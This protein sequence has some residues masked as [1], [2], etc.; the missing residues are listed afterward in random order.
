MANAKMVAG[1]AV[2]VSLLLTSCGP[3]PPEGYERSFFVRA[4]YTLDFDDPSIPLS[5]FTDS[6]ELFVGD[7]GDAD[8][9]AT[10]GPCRIVMEQRGL[11]PSGAIQ[12]SPIP[13]PVECSYESADGSVYDLEFTMADINW[14]VDRFDAELDGSFVSRAPGREDRTGSYRVFVDGF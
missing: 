3:T 10:M 9:V 1:T 12:L 11:P 14:S 8:Y 13:F 7:H 2:L 6:Y 5:T 4:N